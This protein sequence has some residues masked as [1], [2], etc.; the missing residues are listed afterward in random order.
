[1]HQT[2]RKGRYRQI[3]AANNTE[4]DFLR[5]TIA[6]RAKQVAQPPGGSYHRRNI[7]SAYMSQR[8]R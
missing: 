1:M 3:A 7:K 4:C 6:T 8:R 2:F 5:Q